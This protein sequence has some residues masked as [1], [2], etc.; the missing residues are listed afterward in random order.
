[1][2]KGPNGI[3][4]AGDGGTILTT[5]DAIAGATWSQ[6]PSGTSADLA[7][8]IA[9]GSS[10]YF[11][12]TDETIVQVSTPSDSRLINLSCRTQVG[13]GANALITGFVLAG[14]SPNGATP[15]LIRGSGP[16]LSAF[17]VQGALPDPDLGLFGVSSGSTLLASNSG[18]GGSPA[19]VS[20]AAAVGAFAWTDPS[21]HDDA[22][23]DVLPA[24]PYTANV[25]GQSGDTGIA[26]AEIY[27]ATPTGTSTPGSPRLGNLSARAQVGTGS[28]VLIAGFVVGGTR[29]MQVLIRASGPALV[30]FGVSGTLSD[31][32][33]QVFAG[34][35][36]PA[37]ASNTGWSGD[38]G[39]ASAAAWVGAFPWNAAS[40]DSALLLTLAPGA[41]T[42]QV[43]GAS[44]DGGVALIEVYAVP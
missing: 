2:V 42:A 15:I 32:R 1:M 17:D 11:V 12:G 6:V 41:Y 33:L 29:S 8:G 44:G 10:V 23:L 26:L 43:T 38:P 19:V 31:P 20:T 39:I 25:T 36:F 16:A 22:L 18:W 30:P 13:S 35:N 28:A 4:A 14:G 7:G 5:G 40:A 27:D 21:S 34:S 9:I 37:L 24:G 3:F